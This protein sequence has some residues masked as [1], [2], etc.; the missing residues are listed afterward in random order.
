MRS[1]ISPIAAHRPTRLSPDGNDSLYRF[2]FLTQRVSRWRAG[3]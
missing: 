2:N 3:R 1:C